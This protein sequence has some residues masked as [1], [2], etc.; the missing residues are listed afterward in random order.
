MT[1][2]TLPAVSA[3]RPQPPR[4]VLLIAVLCGVQF[5]VIL[6]SLAVALALPSIAHDLGLAPD[7]LSWVVNAYS[8]ALASGLLL[9][10]RLGDV[11]GRRPVLISGV[12]LLTAGALL[13]GLA[14]GTAVLLA[15]RVL[16]GV[17]AAL[18]YPP[19]LA[20]TGDCFPVDPWRS[21]AYAG[22]AISGASGTVAGAAFGG[23]VTGLLGWHWV[24]LLT[25][26]AGVALLAAG[27]G[28]LPSHP[29]AGARRRQLNLPGVA[30]AGGVV[31]TLVLSLA[32]AER[33]GAAQWAGIA[34]LTGTAVLGAAFLGWERRVHD[35]LIPARLLRSRRLLGGCAGIAANSA[36]YTAVVFIGTLHLQLRLGLTPMATGLAFLPLSA[37]AVAAGTWLVTPLRRRFGSVPVAGA[38][39]LLGT[40]ALMLLAA[41]P[42]RP[43]YLRDLL[44]GLVLIG[45][46]LT[47]A[48]VSLTEHTIGGID[49][50]HRGVA[51]GLF[52]TST[53]VAGALAVSLY[54]ELLTRGA[55]Y[56]AAYLSGAALTVTGAAGAMTLLGRGR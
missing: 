31:A 40:G 6:D 32:R 56:P 44:P 11:Y 41:A 33:H 15:G 48:F 5:L 24:F 46:A 18:A 20:L 2:A 23:I 39:L 34:G 35:R 42:A 54:A 53:H 9:G 26:P 37:A 14:P 13:A 21:R 50:A 8:V 28:V 38:G 30:L 4:P 51:S 25:V 7:R 12:S 19:A 36:L 29:R 52:E 17:G 43:S 10:G 22:A 45:I 47:A 3:A 16:Q 55:G 27:R 49:A 1:T